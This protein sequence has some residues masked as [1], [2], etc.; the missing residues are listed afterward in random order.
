MKSAGMTF[1][2]WSDSMCRMIFFATSCSFIPE[3]WNSPFNPQS[4]QQKTCILIAS[5]GL[6][7]FPHGLLNKCKAMMQ[8]TPAA[9][10]WKY[11]SHEIRSITGITSNDSS[12]ED[13]GVRFEMVVRKEE[14]RFSKNHDL[15]A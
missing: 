7:R 4:L 10:T 3:A 13:N 6:Q 1:M 14:H 8:C 9:Y 5:Y 12:I 11:F 2:L 15:I